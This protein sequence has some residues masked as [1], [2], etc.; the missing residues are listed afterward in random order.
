MNADETQEMMDDIAVVVR[1]FT[2]SVIAPLVARL[3]EAES[4]LAAFVAVAEDAD[5][6]Y[7]ALEKQIADK[8]ASVVNGR[9]GRDGVDGKDGAP[10]RDGVDG[11]AG[12]PGRDGV[13]GKDGADGKDGVGIV[14]ISP[15]EDGLMI[16][17]SDDRSLIIG[18]FKGA[19]GKDGRDGKDADPITEGQI[20][21]AVTAYLGANPP[22]AGRD[23][24][25]GLDGAAGK[26]GAPGRDGIDGRDG[27]R[28]PEG[29]P[30]KLPKVKEWSDGV[31]YDGDAVTH[32]GSLW[33]ALRDTGKPPGGDDWRLIASKGSNGESGKDGRSLTVKGTYDPEHSYQALDGVTM[34]GSFFVAKVDDPGPCPGEGWQLAASK[35]GRGQQGERGERGAPGGSV[36]AFEVDG[37]GVLTIRCADGSTATCDLYPLLARL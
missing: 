20:A 32:E 25:D 11:K 29:P 12:A 21:S 36:A 19:D 37:D 23:G 31:H 26:D 4:K 13:D 6:R 17:L 1:A 5:A 24:K 3:D 2:E 9:D 27:E 18:P 7:A 30:G 35:G 16:D 28:G 22:P 8:L 10:G 34:N 33:Q 15:W 14:T